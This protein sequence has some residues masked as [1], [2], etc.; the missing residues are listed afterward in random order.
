MASWTMSVT[1]G[2]IW[3]TDAEGEREKSM[4][5]HIT[6]KLLSSEE[7]QDQNLEL[8]DLLSKQGSVRACRRRT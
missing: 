4:Q 6:S 7:T 3:W 1:I 8:E 2:A 5:R